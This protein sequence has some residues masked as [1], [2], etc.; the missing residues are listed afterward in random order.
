MIKFKNNINNVSELFKD[1]LN[2][3]FFFQHFYVSVLR[4]GDS[5]QGH[6][7]FYSTLKNIKKQICT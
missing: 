5:I 7:W 4:L 2:N 3:S 6:E 1:I